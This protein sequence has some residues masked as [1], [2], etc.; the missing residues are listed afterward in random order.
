MTYGPVDFIAI[1]FKGNHFK[2]ELMPALLDLVNN[3][4]I[5]VI[6]LVIVQK[7]ANG[8]VRMQEMQQH[9]NSVL[10]LFDPS[11]TEITGMIQQDDLQMIGEKVENDTTAAVLLFENLWAIKFKQ[12]VLN[13]KG[14]VVMQERIP[15]DVVEEVFKA[16]S[17]VEKDEL[18]A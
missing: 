11:K 14:Q 16:I 3:D 9:D 8:N 2:G 15:H 12:A 17:A 4:I 1:E 5:R 10:A 6:D 7:D 13:A 18:E